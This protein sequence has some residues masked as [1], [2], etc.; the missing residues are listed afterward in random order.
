MR[1][2]AYLLESSD[3][4]TVVRIID[5]EGITADVQVFA[6]GSRTVLAGAPFVVYSLIRTGNEDEDERA[7]RAAVGKAREEGR[8]ELR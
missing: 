2:T 4:Y 8:A 1:A 7:F 5:S 6:T 3:T